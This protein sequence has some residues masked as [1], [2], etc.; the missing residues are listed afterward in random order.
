MESRGLETWRVT[1]A[2]E[3]LDVVLAVSPDGQ[4]RYQVGTVRRWAACA[5]E[6]GCLHLSSGGR[7]LV[8]EEKLPQ[9]VVAD[10]TS[11]GTL[12]S[13]ASGVVTSLSVTP[14]DQVEAGQ[15]ALTLES[16]KIESP[17]ICSVP[18]KVSEVRVAVGDQVSQRQVLVVIE[19]ADAAT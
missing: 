18:G 6:A 13:P 9:G 8:V 15:R 1:V 11:D 16:M 5:W 19:T 17:L 14:G 7:G 4:V 3:P 10:E 2:D 12:R